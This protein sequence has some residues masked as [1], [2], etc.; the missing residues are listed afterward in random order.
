MPSCRMPS[1]SRTLPCTFHCPTHVRMLV[2]G[3]ARSCPWIASA[4][5]SS[6]ITSC[7]QLPIEDAEYRLNG[8]AK[9]GQHTDAFPACLAQPATHR[10]LL[11]KPCQ[12]R[13]V[14]PKPAPIPAVADHRLPRPADPTLI[15]A[16]HPQQPRRLGC[17]VLLNTARV[18]IRYLHLSGCGVL[19]L[20]LSK[21]DG[22]NPAFFLNTG[23]P[24]RAPCPCHTRPCHVYCRPRPQPANPA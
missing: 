6:W 9:A 13:P 20:S 18:M 14:L 7:R 2:G 1:N 23:L 16:R 10:N 21:R 12:P 17:H 8:T 5:L 3:I 11:R 15:S 19:P 24:P 4:M 22:R